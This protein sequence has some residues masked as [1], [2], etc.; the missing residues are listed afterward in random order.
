MTPEEFNNICKEF[1][2]APDSH[3]WGEGHPVFCLAEENDSL[4]KRV[5]ELA[6]DARRYQYLRSADL[7]AIHKGGIFAGKMPDKVV[8]NMADLDEAI[9]AALDESEYLEIPAF[10]RRE[11]VIPRHTTMLKLRHYNPLGRNVHTIWVGEGNN[12]KRIRIAVGKTKAEAE[13]N[14]LSELHGLIKQIDAEYNGP[15]SSEGQS[16]SELARLVVLPD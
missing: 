4:K 13:E 14:A 16:D 15:E 10:L 8:I 3:S 5:R 1:D 7:D 12:R 9:D 2:A 11:R 6:A